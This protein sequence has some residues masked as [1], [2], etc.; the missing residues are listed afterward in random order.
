MVLHLTE[1]CFDRNLRSQ[2]ESQ[3]T[4][5]LRSTELR[6]QTWTLDCTQPPRS[7][8][9][10]FDR[11]Y[12]TEVIYISSDKDYSGDR[13]DV[14]Q[15]RNIGLKLRTTDSAAAVYS[16]LELSLDTVSSI[17]HGDKASMADWIVF[18]H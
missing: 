18:C 7:V 5:G 8:E 3:R 6:N 17:I 16:L 14:K 11:G 12:S 2:E 10:A 15:Q 4:T 13:T 1:V 9:L